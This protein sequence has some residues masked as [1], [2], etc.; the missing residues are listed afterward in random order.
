M[1][2]DTQT[3]AGAGAA[4]GGSV[5]YSI[6]YMRRTDALG[7]A[8]MMAPHSLRRHSLPAALLGMAAGALAGTA[9]S[10]LVGDELR[11]QVAGGAALGAA[12]GAALMTAALTAPTVLVNWR[13][14]P[15]HVPAGSMLPT[16][17][18][19]AIN[20]TL[21]WGLTGLSIGTPIGAIAVPLA[22]RTQG[23]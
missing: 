6:D 12:G 19:M 10:A 4:V 2:K 13:K 7:D 23:T 11:S 1:G 14:F 8:S 20:E 16:R 5:A 15:K 22:S 3:L 18:S 21:A 17:S 9:L